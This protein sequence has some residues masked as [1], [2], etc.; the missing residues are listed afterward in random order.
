MGS[1]NLQGDRLNNISREP[2]PVFNHSHCKEMF[3][4]VQIEPPEFQF[5]FTALC[6]FSAQA[7]NGLALSSSHSPYLSTVMRSP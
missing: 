1:K 7:E 2:V 4:D 3:P 6:W 5:M